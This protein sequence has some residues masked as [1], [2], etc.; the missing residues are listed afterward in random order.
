MTA[1]G[2]VASPPAMLIAIALTM[3]FSGTA[4]AE[5]GWLWVQSIVASWPNFTPAAS[6]H[7]HVKRARTALR[8]VAPA[9]PKLLAF[10]SARE[11][12]SDCFWCSRP[13]YISGLSF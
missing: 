2:R 6:Q 13:V 1:F 4:R 8:S 5:T 11:S 10:V 7:P 3:C 9:P 12:R